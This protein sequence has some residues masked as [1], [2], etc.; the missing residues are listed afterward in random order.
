MT[1]WQGFIGLAA[2][3]VALFAWLRADM[4]RI[5]GRMDRLEA[6]VSD[7]RER[8]SRLKGVME[9]LGAAIGAGAMRKDS[10]RGAV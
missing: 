4:T 3:P 8:M 7:L 5:A 6:A 1:E 10:R 2:L 9:R